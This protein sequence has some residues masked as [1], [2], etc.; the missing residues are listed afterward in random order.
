M[1]R[2]IDA[3][4]HGFTLKA[5]PRDSGGWRAKA[6]GH[7]EGVHAPDVPRPRPGPF[8]DVPPATLK[9]IMRQAGLT[10]EQLREML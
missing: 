10:R 1:E 9:S 4:G 3:Q 7:R 2:K 8:G 6:T 5:T